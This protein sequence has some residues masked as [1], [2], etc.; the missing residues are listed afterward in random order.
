MYWQQIHS[1]NLVFCR[2]YRGVIATNNGGVIVNVCNSMFC[3]DHRGAKA[4]NMWV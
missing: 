1:C 3:G 2:D 4:T